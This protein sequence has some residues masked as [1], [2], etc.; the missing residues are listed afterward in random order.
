MHTPS[1][2][3]LL[4]LEPKGCNP[5]EIL[6]PPT[7]AVQS[8]W[9]PPWARALSMCWWATSIVGIGTLWFSASWRMCLKVSTRACE[10]SEH[11]DSC[12][13]G[14][15]G[16]NHSSKA[17]SVAGHAGEGYASRAECR[18]RIKARLVSEEREWV[19][20]IQKMYGWDRDVASR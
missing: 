15:M 6:S 5:A 7:N 12:C 4:T 14:I 2:R 20:S 10:R 11:C 17:R 9:S 1:E 16:R 8:I 18:P 3:R 19:L 13:S